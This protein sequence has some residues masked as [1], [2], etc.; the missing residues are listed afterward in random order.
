MHCAFVIFIPMSAGA[1]MHGFE[2]EE[3]R[4]HDAKAVQGEVD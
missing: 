2:I 3:E 1:L 4:I